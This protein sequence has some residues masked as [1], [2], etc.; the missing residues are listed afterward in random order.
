MANSIG[1]LGLGWVAL[2]ALSL[3][4]VVLVG[5]RARQRSARLAAPSGPVSA[6]RTPPLPRHGDVGLATFESRKLEVDHEMSGALA[7]LRDEALRD[8][9]E[10]QVVVQPGLAVWADPHALRQML[11]GIVSQAIERAE[12]S[13][14]LV[15]ASWH[16]GRTQVIVMDDGPAGDPAI[17]TGRLRE[18]EQCAALQGGTLE[19]ECRPHRGTKVLLRMP[20]AVAPDAHPTDDDVTEEMTA[21]GAPSTGMLSAS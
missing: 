1:F 15:S 4:F 6:N 20:G 5:W 7:Q 19:L 3:G 17:L 2:S 12:G 13:A 11:L 10:L 14:L 16:G 9:V 18:V 21:A 8:Q